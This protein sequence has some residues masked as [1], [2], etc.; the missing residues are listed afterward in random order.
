MRLTDLVE[1][2]GLEIRTCRSGLD[3][4]VTGGYASDLMSDVIAHAQSGSVWVTLQ[5]H[6]NVAAIA[7]MKDLSAVILVQGR[8]PEPAMA[9]K[10]EAEN[11]P[12]L[13]SNLSAFEL[14]GRLYRL[15]VKGA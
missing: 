13:V 15:G 3:R 10:A 5:V 1:E 11:I 14:I 9:E 8:V 7:S 12:V 4:Q 6:V 2:L